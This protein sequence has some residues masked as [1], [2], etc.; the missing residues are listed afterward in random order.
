MK[1]T[2]TTIFL[3]LSMIAFGQKESNWWFFGT[4]GGVNFNCIPPMAMNGIEQYEYE[5]KDY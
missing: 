1:N 5:D 4:R 3:L 2:L